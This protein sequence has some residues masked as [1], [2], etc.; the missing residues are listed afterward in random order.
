MA[1]SDT[2]SDFSSDPDLDDTFEAIIGGQVPERAAA[3]RRAADRGE[4][5]EDELG[6]LVEAH[7][8]TLETC[9]SRCKLRLI[10]GAQFRCGSCSARPDLAKLLPEGVVEAYAWRGYVAVQAQVPADRA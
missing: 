1:Q 6:R 3:A 2:A 10:P 9:H 7:Q 8:D 4:L 5:S